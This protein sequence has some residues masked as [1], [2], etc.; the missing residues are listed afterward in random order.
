MDK[1][2]KRFLGIGVLAAIAVIT[3]AFAIAASGSDGGGI[4]KN[5][6]GVTVAAS[7]VTSSINYQGRLTDSAGEPLSGTYTMTFRLYDVVSGGAALDT[8]TNTVEV[9]DGLFNTNIDFNQSY[10]DGRALWLGITVGGD[11]EMTQRQ[12]LKPVPYALSLVPGARIDGSVSGSVLE[13]NNTETGAGVHGVYGET[14][15]NWGWASG[16]YGKATEDYAI[17]VTGRNTG[18]GAGVY[19]WSNEGPGV[20]GTSDNDTGMYGIGKY[21]GYFTTNLAGT[22]G[23]HNAG[24]NATTT[25]DYSDGVRAST[26]GDDSDG[27][28]ASTT[29]NHSEG[30]LVYTTGY[31]SEGLFAET[32]GYGSDGVRAKTTGGNSQGISANTYGDGSEGVYVHTHGDDS[33]GVRAHTHGNDS[34]AV[35][36]STWGDY[37]YGVRA[38]TFGGGSDGVRVDTSGGGSDGVRVDTSGGGSDGVHAHT[39]GVESYGVR[40]YTSGD[41]S[42]GVHAHT[43][44]VGSAGVR[45]STSGDYSRGVTAHTSGTNSSGVHARST[46]YHGVYGRT[47]SADSAG[48]YARGKDSGADLI[49]GG[50]ADTTVGDDGKIYSDPDY[51]SSDIFLITN[52]GIGIVLDNDGDGEDADFEIRDKDNKRIFNVDE[53]GDVTYGGP[54]IAAF[55]RPA[56]DS[57]WVSVSKGATKT[58]THNL[59]GNADNYVVDM[60]FKSSMYGRNQ[61]RYGG[62]HFRSGVVPHQRLGAYWSHLDDTQINVYRERA[63]TGVS[64]VR[65]RIWVYK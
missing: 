48:V 46:N 40:A 15:G 6:E 34:Y 31:F 44:G 24:V 17:G 11:E 49:L 22:S 56:Y 54:N 29:G 33:Y 39:T 51:P 8:D 3:I 7:A 20:I 27:V 5:A 21:G 47:D 36:A 10:F 62:Y 64:Y 23:N 41:G 4:G 26:T 59:G 30:V 16:V 45:V 13:I 2:K 60:Q 37:S 61:R 63:D 35:Y 58:L 14:S 12:E 19:G 25:H 18:G 53:S 55:P 32:T 1:T 28:H 42:D 57:G 43:T 50:N 38:Y 9:T 65:V 52:D